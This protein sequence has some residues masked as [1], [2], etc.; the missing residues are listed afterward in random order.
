MSY[1][2]L[3]KM[4]GQPELGPTQQQSSAAGHLRLNISN[5]EKNGARYDSPL[6]EVVE[7]EPNGPLTD[8][9]MDP[10]LERE[11]FGSSP[12]SPVPQLDGSVLA[13]EQTTIP[14]NSKDDPSSLYDGA[15]NETVPIAGHDANDD[16]PGVGAALPAV[17]EEP[18]ASTTFAQDTA[19]VEI[20]TESNGVEPQQ[21]HAKLDEKAS[22][23]AL[24]PPPAAPA[25]MLPQ[26][27]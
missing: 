18:V 23:A 24:M 4:D 22:A 9:P 2:N 7:Q 14:E 12:N 25:S 26:L 8:S 16:D 1:V 5:L 13:A 19:V 11:L 10:D 21:M 20:P 17:A 6:T 3:V 15:A 27:Q